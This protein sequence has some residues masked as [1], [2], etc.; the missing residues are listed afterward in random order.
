MVCRFLFHLQSGEESRFPVLLHSENGL[1]RQTE[2]LTKTRHTV[3][4]TGRSVGEGCPQT[5]QNQIKQKPQGGDTSK[6]RALFLLGEAQEGLFGIYW[7]AFWRRVLLLVMVSQ[8]QEMC[9]IR[10]EPCVP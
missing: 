4:C 7:G 5:T 1:T 10:G 3:S 9:E 6:E 2:L 8:L